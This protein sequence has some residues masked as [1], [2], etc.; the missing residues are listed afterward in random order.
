MAGTF[1]ATSGR[2]VSVGNVLS[3][4]FATVGAQPALFL[5][6]SFG[7][8]ALPLLLVTQSVGRT[9]PVSP[10]AFATYGQLWPMFVGGG[11]MWTLIYL[12][13]KALLI[14]ATVA[15]LDGRPEAPGELLRAA[16]RAGLP[17]FG[18]SILF[19]LAVWFGLLVLL[20]PG[21]MLATIWAVAGPAL[22]V[23][24]IGVFA[25]FGRSARLTRGARWR[26]LGLVLLIFAIYLVASAALG[27]VGGAAAIGTG[28]PGTW[29]E[30]LGSAVMQTLFT[31][32]WSA[33]QGSLYV[34]LRDWKDGPGGDRLADIFA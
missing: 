12:V 19:W 32:V 34:E 17:L 20:V 23:E 28:R 30:A 24:R 22:V 7:L 4:A 25:A 21:I 18:L 1:E 6:I 26:I 2:T 16:L 31:A 29:V 15:G 5:G 13:A 11:L 9:S 33:V 8:G 27:F 10:G 14:R 3:R